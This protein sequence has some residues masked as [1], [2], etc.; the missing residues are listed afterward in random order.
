[1]PLNLRCDKVLSRTS[2]IPKTRD[3]T[4]FLRDIL[5]AITD[6]QQ[7]VD[8]IDYETF[9]KDKKTNQAVV[10]SLEI[11]GEAMKHVPPAF[12]AKYQQIPWK[13][14]SGLRDKLS[15]DY[16]GIDL[17]IVW[18]TISEELPKSSNLSTKS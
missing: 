9:T 1:M 2:F 7:F 6:I 5:N 10:R 4:I 16:F 3:I 12:R 15:H 14:Y 17:E 8:Q 11:I 13:E 18:D